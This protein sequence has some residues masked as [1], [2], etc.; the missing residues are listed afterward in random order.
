MFPY[1]ARRVR[2]ICPLDFNVTP[3]PAIANFVY[4]VYTS[5]HSIEST[6]ARDNVFFFSPPRPSLC[7]LSYIF[8]NFFPPSPFCLYVFSSFF[9]LSLSF[10]FLFSL[11]FFF[12]NPIT[13]K[14]CSD[15]DQTRR[16]PISLF[17]FR[18]IGKRACPRSRHN[19]SSRRLSK[20]FLSKRYL[21]SSARRRRNLCPLCAR[22]VNSRR[23]RNGPKRVYSNLIKGFPRSC[24]RRSTDDPGEATIA[25]GEGRRDSELLLHSGGSATTSDSLAEKRKESFP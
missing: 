20:R 6:N 2:A 22:L 18:P 16:I 23:N 17:S 13:R 5:F 15:T 11:F 9:S 7:F 14:V 25:A 19:R 3:F 24:A 1:D 8:P 10:F 21:L 4:R 12:F